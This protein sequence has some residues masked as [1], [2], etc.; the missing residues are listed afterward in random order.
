[1]GET[2]SPSFRLQAT[3]G[4]SAWTGSVGLFFGGLAVAS[5]QGHPGVRY[6]CVTIETKTLRGQPAYQLQREI[7]DIYPVQGLRYCSF[8]SRQLAAVKIE[9]LAAETTLEVHVTHGVLTAVIRN[10]TAIAELAPFP[11]PGIEIPQDQPKIF[12]ITNDSGASTFRDVRVMLI[13]K[14]VRQ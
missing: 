11:N 9:P 10:G 13:E 5:E 2:R 1:V 3:I 6:E 12:G 8:Q 4:R 14:P 7:C